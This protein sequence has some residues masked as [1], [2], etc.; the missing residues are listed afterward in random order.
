[1]AEVWTEHPAPNIYFDSTF[2]EEELAACAEKAI[3][4]FAPKLILGISDEMSSRG[5][6]ER[7][8]LVGRIVDDYNAPAAGSRRKTT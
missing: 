4:L 6:I 2:S 3:A 1:M 7:I 8:R 5:D